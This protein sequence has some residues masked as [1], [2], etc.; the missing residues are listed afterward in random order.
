MTS[1]MS[2]PLNH[3]KFFINTIY[4]HNTTSILIYQIKN[5]ILSQ[6][7]FSSPHT[8]NDLDGRAV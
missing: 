3:Y 4:S 5:D 8:I 7:L 6:S 1:T 2:Q